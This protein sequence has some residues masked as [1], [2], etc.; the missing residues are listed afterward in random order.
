MRLTITFGYKGTEKKVDWWQT[1][2]DF[3]KLLKYSGKKYEWI[4]FDK[5][6]DG[7]GGHK[8]IFSEISPLD[9]IF[10]T[11]MKNFEDMFESGIKCECGAAHS[12]FPWDHMR[13]CPLWKPW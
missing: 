8:L 10:H 2:E 11:D 7:F 3:P 5:D 1:L 4:M 9:P 6:H 13:Y 12:Q